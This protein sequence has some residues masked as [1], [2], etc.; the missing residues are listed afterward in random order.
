MYNKLEMLLTDHGFVLWIA[1]ICIF[2]LMY[3]RSEHKNRERQ[4]EAAMASEADKYDAEE[5]VG[6]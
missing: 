1:M 2:T 6:M 4:R 5:P 3:I